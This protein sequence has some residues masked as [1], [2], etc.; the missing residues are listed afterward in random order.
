[1]AVLAGLGVA[2]QALCG[3]A[4]RLVPAAAGAEGGGQGGQGGQAVGQADQASLHG[5]LRGVG[6][7][8]AWAARGRRAIDPTWSASIV[9]LCRTGQS[10]PVVPA[11]RS[12]VF[13]VAVVL[14]AALAVPLFG[15]RLS[16]L[17]E[18]R[19]RHIWAVF[20]ALGL[21]I[22]A[23]EP[24]G[25]PEAS[26]STPALA[27]LVLTPPKVGCL[28]PACWPPGS[29]GDSWRSCGTN[30]PESSAMGRP[31]SSAARIRRPP[32]AAPPSRRVRPRASIALN[33]AHGQP[34]AAGHG[35]AE[36]A[37]C[38]RHRGPDWYDQAPYQ[39][40]AHPYCGA[41]SS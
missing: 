1:L 10:C 36:V 26:T 14:L 34:P 2:V 6:H 25:L 12:W 38:P 22:A 11:R 18:V 23:M 19:L 28:P 31:G 27:V 7:W 4:G 13:P 30:A 24:P 39:A 37:V 41:E 35:L 20:A 16:A 33:R 3:L 5:D 21:K 17:V 32:K 29:P 8:T 40:R 15:G 9:G